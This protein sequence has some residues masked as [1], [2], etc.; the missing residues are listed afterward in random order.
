MEGPKGFRLLWSG[1]SHAGQGNGEVDLTALET[2]YKELNITVEVLKGR[3]LDFPRI[4]RFKEHSIELPV[5]SIDVLPQNE[6]LL[7]ESLA[8]ALEH[9]KGVVHVLSE[10]TGLKAAMMAGAPTGGIGRVQVGIAKA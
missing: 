8:R 2:A 1:D 5:A 10:L 3:S 7:R 4:D 9:G 6:A